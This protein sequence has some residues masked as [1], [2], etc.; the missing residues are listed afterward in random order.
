MSGWLSGRFRRKPAPRPDFQH[1]SLG[2]GIFADDLENWIF[3]VRADGEVLTIA[4]AGDERPD[5]G[6]LERA[7]ALVSDFGRVKDRVS[8]FN[9]EFCATYGL[10]PSQSAEI[11]GLRIES[12]H[13]SWPERP[14]ELMIYFHDVETLRAWRMHVIDGEPVEL[15]FDD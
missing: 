10:P 12:A 1:P 14:S 9:R 11:D 2:R 8:T 6:L 15:G 7:H 3:Q 5:P 4:V 13:F